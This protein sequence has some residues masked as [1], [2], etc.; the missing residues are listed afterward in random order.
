MYRNI[1]EIL[2]LIFYVYILNIN[3]FAQNALVGKWEGKSSKNKMISL[4]FIDQENAN[5]IKE[6]GGILNGKRVTAIFNIKY[7]LLKNKLLIL[8]Y[9]GWLGKKNDIF[10]CPIVFKQ[11]N[12]I[13]ISI[14]TLATSGKL[15]KQIQEIWYLTKEK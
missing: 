2:L 1:P 12:K 4:E 9:G 3:I 7:S 14:P 5:L 6:D 15:K 13:E 8:D 10:N 11:K